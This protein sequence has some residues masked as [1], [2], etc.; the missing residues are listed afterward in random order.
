MPSELWDFFWLNRWLIGKI[1]KIGADCF[2]SISNKQNIVPGIFSAIHTFGRD[3]KRNIHLHLSI[4][5]GGITVDT[6]CWKALFFNKSAIEK[7]WKYKIISLFRT[8]YQNQQLKIP[9]SIQ[10]QLNNA[11][12]FEQFL[13]CL[14]RKKWIV[15]LAKST[16]TP[17]L[18]IDYLGGYFKRPVI[19]EAKLKHY[20]GQSV[21]FK[22]LDRRYN[23]YTTK[24]FSVEDFIAKFVQ[25]IPDH[26]FRMIR[27]YG[28]LSNRLRGKLLPAV[29]EAL[30]QN[31]SKQTTATSFVDLMKQSFKVDPLQCILCGYQ[32]ALTAIVFGKTKTKGL[33]NFHKELALLHII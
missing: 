27:Y 5:L 14:Y 2:L 7:Q 20:D 9:A 13:D 29:Y 8:A 24:T 4:T 10:K 17:K 21:T 12:T 16:P 25:H 26:N 32:L 23:L 6:G 15:D 31:V 22:Y 30:K 33:I 28:F 3:L 1:S 11:F 19:A 18:T